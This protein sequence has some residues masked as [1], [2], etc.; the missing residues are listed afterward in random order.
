MAPGQSCARLRAA[1]TTLSLP[2]PTSSK[3]LRSDDLRSLLSLLAESGTCTAPPC[4]HL[5]RSLLPNF[6][7]EGSSESSLTSH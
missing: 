7:L 2:V 1:A 3:R 4:K 5:Q 6:T